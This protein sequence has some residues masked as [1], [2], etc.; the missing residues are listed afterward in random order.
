MHEVHMKCKTCSD[1]KLDYRLTMDTYMTMCTHNNL[2][3]IF[4]VKSSVNWLCHDVQNDWCNF[5]CSD[6][7]M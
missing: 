4:N 6:A 5:S 1:L 7:I 2:K 3:D